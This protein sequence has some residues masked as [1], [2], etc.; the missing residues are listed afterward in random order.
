MS[1]RN[2]IPSLQAS[3][4]S[5]IICD[6]PQL[7]SKSNKH[8]KI[9]GVKGGRVD[10]GN[11]T[12]KSYFNLQKGKSESSENLHINSLGATNLHLNSEFAESTAQL[13]LK[14]SKPTEA[15]VGNSD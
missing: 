10:K 3:N 13:S 7:K 11:K 12:I 8:S 5:G 14:R 4:T 9:K 6:S 15:E 1:I 2:Y